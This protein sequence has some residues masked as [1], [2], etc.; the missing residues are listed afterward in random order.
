M[1]PAGGRGMTFTVSVEEAGSALAGFLRGR[2]PDKPWSEVKRWIATGKVFVDGARRRA[3]GRARR[4]PGR[5]SSCGWRRRAGV[6]RER[7]LVYDDAHVVVI[8]KPAGVSSVPYEE[9]EKGTAMDLIRD[10]WRRHGAAGD[11][12]CAPRRAP[13]RQGDVGP[14]RVR[15]DQ[16]RRARAGGAAP[17]AHRRAPATSASRTAT[18]GR[19][20]SSA[21]SSPTAATACAAR[22]GGRGRA[23]AR[24]RTS[25][26]STRCAA[27]P[28]ARSG[29]RPA[30]P[31]RSA[32][33]SPRPAIRSSARRSTSAT[34][35]ARTPS[36]RRG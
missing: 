7:A 14:P 15:Q 23:S 30:R 10:A 35:A 13:H 1:G 33:T 6:E 32:S 3:R 4:A 9:R 11:R 28:C 5:L 17:R 16:A 21:T 27:R 18:C 12:A 22:R 8:D 24:S 19:R 2:Q 34:F 36:R 31:T 29:S 26:P 20:G 25:S